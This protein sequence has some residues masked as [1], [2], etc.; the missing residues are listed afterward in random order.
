M[1]P[2]HNTA[3]ARSAGALLGVIVTAALDDQMLFFVA[4]MK[5]GKKPLPTSTKEVNDKSAN[6]RSSGSQGKQKNV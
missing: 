3:T 5:A 2:V 4:E 1:Q 6:N